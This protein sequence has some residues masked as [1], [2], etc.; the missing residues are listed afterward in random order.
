MKCDEA[1]CVVR[2]PELDTGL[3]LV[4]VVPSP[5]QPLF[6]TVGGRRPQALGPGHRP[7]HRHA[8]CSE[9]PSS[10]LPG[11]AHPPAL[12]AA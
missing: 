5:Q 3:F 1:V 8:L 10:C 6:P 9:L 4:A 11:W 12:V 2:G 7:T